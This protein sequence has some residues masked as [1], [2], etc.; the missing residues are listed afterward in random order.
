[1]KF[2]PKNKT[3]LLVWRDFKSIV[4]DNTILGILST[5]LLIVGLILVLSSGIIGAGGANIDIGVS[6]DED[7]HDEYISSTISDEYD[8]A[9]LEYQDEDALREAVLEG[10]RDAGIHVRQNSADSYHLTVYYP[11]NEL[12]SFVVQTTLQPALD[13]IENQINTKEDNS[14][15]SHIGDLSYDDTYMSSYTVLFQLLFFTTVFVSGA[16]II[17][18]KTERLKDGSFKLISTTP[19][20]QKNKI[21]SKIYVAVIISTIQFMTWAIILY[22]S[23]FDFSNPLLIFL[24]LVLFTAFSSLIAISITTIIEERYQ[25]QIA[26]SIILIISILFL[27]MLPRNP[28]N[29][30]SLIILNQVDYDVL[31]T[32]TG[33]I[34]VTC[35]GYISVIW[36][37]VS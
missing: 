34:F 16:I 20:S 25:A 7:F 24:L 29:T 15:L 5:H 26:F 36:W 32:I 1:M 9:T 6:G 10:E 35:V 19:I 31:L 33:Y 11:D 21:H 28:A 3:L 12:E 27:S 14:M 17:D 37:K 4:D 30:I 22:F 18:M 13:D 8:I 23:W 2:I